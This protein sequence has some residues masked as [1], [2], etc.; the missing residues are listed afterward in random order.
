MKPL[1]LTYLIFSRGHKAHKMGNTFPWKKNLHSDDHK[2]SLICK[3]IKNIVWKNN[4]QRFK[5]NA[6]SQSTILK[7]ADIIFLA[8]IDTILIILINN[9]EQRTNLGHWSQSIGSNRPGFEPAP[10]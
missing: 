7:Q 9:C 4:Y 10:I 8:R 2:D 1:I 3:Y 6:E 5:Q